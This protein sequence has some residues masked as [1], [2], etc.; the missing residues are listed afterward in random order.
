MAIKIGN[1]K[2]GEN[3]TEPLKLEKQRFKNKEMRK[4][5]KIYEKLLEMEKIGIGNKK[6][7]EF[8]KKEKL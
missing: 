8:D 2:V 6:L 5:N 3:P 7:E 1:R 4:E